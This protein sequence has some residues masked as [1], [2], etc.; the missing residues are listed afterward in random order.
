MRC[1]KPVCS[2]MK[3]LL[4]LDPKVSTETARGL[5]ALG[6]MTKA[7][8]AGHV[9]TRLVPP[10]TPEEAAEL[11]RSFLR[12]TTAAI[13]RAASDHNACGIAVYT[14]V[15]TES[16]YTN[17]LPPDFRLLPQRGED[18]GERLYL[19]AQDLFQCGFSYACLI[20]SDSPTVPADNYAAAVKLLKPPGNR[21]VLGPSED[22]GYYLIGLKRP[23]RELFERIDWSTGRVLAQTKQRAD[24]MGV[25][26]MLL[27]NGYDVDDAASL[28]RLA[29]ELLTATA[30][31]ELA[32]HTQRFLRELSVRK[33]L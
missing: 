4:L 22:G 25:E 1:E 29:D 18:F 33:S 28:R 21:I 24:E 3:P 12:D 11:N 17:L 23:H 10:L 19:A 15:G 13:S 9:K 8:R 30:P 7:P 32:P 16:V 6:V 2:R 27:P 26:V 14:P 31:K 5:C 20:D